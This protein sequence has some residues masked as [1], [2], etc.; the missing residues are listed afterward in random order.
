MNKNSLKN[1]IPGH[2]RNKGSKNK[3]TNLKDSF[4]Q[5]FQQMGGTQALL[6]WGLQQ[7]NRADF[8]QMIARML[9][10]KQDTELSGSLSL[11]IKRE[12]IAGAKDNDK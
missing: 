4:L 11:Q 1:I 10:T 3:F 6:E 5:A 8:Y 2:G 12:I 9:P 7:R